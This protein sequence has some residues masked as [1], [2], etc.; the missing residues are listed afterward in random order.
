MAVKIRLRRVGAKKQ[1]SYRLVAADSA[2]PRDGRFLETLGFYNPRT[3]PP[4]IQM[5]ESRVVH[6]L[7]RGAQ[8]S[9]TARRLLKK[10]G[11]LQRWQE[12]KAASAE[13]SS[14]PSEEPA[15]ESEGG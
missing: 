5:E 13:R 12:G 4:T 9:E 14:G 11:V 15:G 6:W 2:C 3:D 7:E 1:P 10:A 8:P